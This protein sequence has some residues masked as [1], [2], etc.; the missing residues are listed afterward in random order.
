MS[1]QTVVDEAFKAQYSP[2]KT[3]WMSNLIG[4]FALGIIGWQSMRFGAV[5]LITIKRYLSFSPSEY[6][7]FVVINPVQVQA[8]QFQVM[9]AHLKAT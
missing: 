1:E 6:S 2:I 5:L 8:F 9:V 7:Q 3:R 4:Y